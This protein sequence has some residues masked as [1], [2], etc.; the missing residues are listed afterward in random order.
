ME[1]VIGPL[2]D[3]LDDVNALDGALNAFAQRLGASVASF[4]VLDRL[5]GS[6]IAMR[7]INA[8]QSAYSRYPDLIP[9]D[10]RFEAAARIPKPAVFIGSQ[11]VDPREGHK[12]LYYRELLEP[13]KMGFML[14]CGVVGRSMGAFITAHRASGKSDIQRPPQNA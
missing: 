7:S 2:Y 14:G 9:V 5:R 1:L 6:T 11:L 4:V 8:P 3:S 13:N 12:S 10:P